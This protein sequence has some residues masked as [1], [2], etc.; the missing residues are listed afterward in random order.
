M[1]TI[2]ITGSKGLI[3]SELSSE[4]VRRGHMV[5]GLDVAESKESDSYG[6]ILSEENLRQKI[7]TCDGVIHLAAVSRV[8]WGEQNPDLCEQVN[9]DGTQNV[10]DAALASKKNPW[11]IY[12]SSREVY[13]QQT[14]L[15]VAENAMLQP[16]NVYGHS[17]YNA[18]NLVKQ[19]RAKGLNTVITRFSNVY[20]S[21]FDHVDRVMPAF[22][23]AAAMGNTL[24]L[25]GSQNTFDF[26]YID[27]VVDGIVLLV[28]KLVAQ[29]NQQIADLHFVS[30][31][32]TTLQ[33]AAE[34]ACMASGNNCQ[35][36]EAP[37]R[38]YD[39]ATFYGDP[40]RA[41]DILGWRATTDLQTGI[42]KLVQAFKLQATIDS[43]SY[44]RYY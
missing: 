11:V 23:Y 35:L 40:T 28:D 37:P 25:E 22:C 9:I 33:Q 36:Q 30:G 21:V 32:G 15:P 43:H 24:R 4:L 3:G 44:S 18:E 1:T 29:I 26:T 42:A 38:N 19:Y 14:I 10:L 16:V 8:I 12:A 17:K 7:H 13:G 31:I 2:L 5:L 41:Q 34:Y 27:D 39:V 6:D 20:G